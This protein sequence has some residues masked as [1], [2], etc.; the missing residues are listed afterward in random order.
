MKK[1]LYIL[2][3]ASLP[4]F[5]FAQQNVEFEKK[6]FPDKKDE[7]KEVIKEIRE[8][9]AIWDLQQS[10]I[11]P[12][13]IPHYLKAQNFNPNNAVL[14]YRL[15]VSYLQT[16]EKSKAY[17]Y[18]TKAYNLNPTVDERIRYYT[19]WVYH[20]KSEWEKAITEYQ[21][22]IASLG[23]KHKEEVAKAAKRIEECKAGIEL[24]KN[25]IRVFIDNVGPEINSSYSD[26]SPVITAD[27]S[28]MM[29]TSRRPGGVSA[30]LSEE[31]NLPY[32]DIW[33]S[34]KNGKKWTNARNIGAPV[35]L[36]LHNAAICLSPDGQKL[37]TYDGAKQ[38]GDLFISELMGL[39]WTKPESLGKAV[40]T[41]GHEA[42]AS[43]SYDSK[44]L[45][46]VSSDRK[47]GMG[48]HDIYVSHISDKGK[49]EKAV[50]IGPPIN[51]SYDEDGVYMMPDG[52]TMYYSSKG[53]GSIGGYD[54]FKTTLENG[55]WTQPVNMGIPI[56]TP[57]DDVFFVL[58]AN[59]RHAFYASASMKGY[60]GQ[61]IY[62]LTILGP[63]KQPLTNTEDQLLAMAANPISNLKTEAAVESKGPKM[64][65]L[66]GVITDAK[67]KEVLEASIDLI[68]NDKNLLLAT[69]KSNSTTGRY[70]VT[71][72]A[73]KNYGIAVR[74]DGYLFHSENFII[75]INADYIEYN[76]DV[77]L[78]K[79]EVGSVIVLRNIFFDF[80]KATI[81][82]ESANELDRLIKLLTENPTIKIELGSH[83]DSKGSD[84]YNMKLSD[85]RSKSVVEY[86]ISKGIP[87]DRL[88]AKGYGE[89][90]PIDTNDTDEGRQ[91]NRRTEFKILSK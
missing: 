61:D 80:D 79:V 62:R 49:F 56:N 47:D 58:A 34:T 4:F 29:F 13:A 5:N 88:T 73:G 31:D 1:L 7:L 42:S 21:A 41:D 14:N 38:G 52:K 86:L 39:S 46:F 85:N 48:G 36:E 53:P 84:E 50:N 32:E 16:H 59:G 2:A 6:N 25:P 65:L 22:Y 26:Y 81:R 44:D 43:F 30:G 27:E 3:V 83:T 19:G 17:D 71:L 35:N 69:F 77:A 45:Y 18:I 72:P 70:L 78:K 91:N 66:K 64:A 60:G 15:G 55:K 12:V 37:I 10:N 87:S 20:L 28:I 63:E 23:G 57:D 89:T 24:A 8:G 33:M 82:P 74:R 90:K 11:Y 67:T 40:N 9:D 75:D 76:K 54:I 68:D 51:T